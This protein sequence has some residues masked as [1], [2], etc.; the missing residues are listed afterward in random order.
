MG[1]PGSGRR[2]S[3]HSRTSGKATQTL[4]KAVVRTGKVK[5]TGKQD[6][7]KNVI[8]RKMRLKSKVGNARLGNYPTHTPGGKNLPKW[9]KGEY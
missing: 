9:R 8:N 6:L 7:L 3:G 2:P 1:G 5:Y 4:K